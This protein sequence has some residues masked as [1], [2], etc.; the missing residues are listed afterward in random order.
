ME[1]GSITLIKHGEKLLELLEEEEPIHIE[2][3]LIINQEVAE[4]KPVYGLEVYSV[5]ERTGY[6]CEDLCVNRASVE[7]L[8]EM[9][10]QGGVTP[11]TAQDVVYDWLVAQTTPVY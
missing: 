9:M 5:Q 3:F 1:R 6:R 7:E 8:L 4:G 10:L 2:Y 11:T